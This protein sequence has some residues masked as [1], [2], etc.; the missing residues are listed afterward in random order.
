MKD[1]ISINYQG[2][3]VRAVG[4]RLYFCEPKQT[5]HDFCLQVL[6]SV[7][8]NKWYQKERQKPEDERHIVA[9]WYMSYCEFREKE[10]LQE[11]EFKSEMI[12]SCLPTGDVWSLT[13]LGYD[14]YSLIHNTRISDELISRLKF[15]NSY[16]GARYE[17]AVA[18]IFARLDYEIKYI[19]DKS[20]KYWEFN[21]KHKQTDEII[22]VEV[23]SRHRPGVL[24]QEG[25]FP[26]IKELKVGISRLL[27]QALE[28]KSN[29]MPFVIFIDINLPLNINIPHPERNWW[30]DLRRA[31][32]NIG[33]AS[34]ESPD[35]FNMLCVTNF[36]YH[37]ANIESINTSFYAD[38]LCVVIPMYPKIQVKNKDTI[39]SIHR[40]VMSYGKVP[41]DW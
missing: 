8:T 21:A 36:S 25:E 18:A 4:S 6:Y 19:D 40:G 23:K 34:K 41:H 22:A 5:F 15:Y 16:Q 11:K 35:N 7:F 37:Y 29:N 1:P 31:T 28:Q 12:K 27:N 20:R 9:K 26:S 32:E 33:E 13:T 24:H 38:D 17:L 30:K 14:L 39:E 10:F 2:K 3:K